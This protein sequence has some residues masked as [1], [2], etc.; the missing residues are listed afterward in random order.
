MEQIERIRRLADEH[1]RRVAREY[2]D[3]R[4]GGT[5]ADRAGFQKIMADALLAERPFDTI[6]VYDLSRFSASSSR[7]HP[8]Q[9]PSI[10]SIKWGSDVVVPQVS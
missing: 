1:G 7:P 5:T 6:I 2:E 10:N 4:D 3:E 8:V 9:G